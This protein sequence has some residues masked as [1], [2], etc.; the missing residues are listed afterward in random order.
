MQIKVP[1]ISQEHLGAKGY[2]YTGG[3][4]RKLP[5]GNTVLDGAMFTEVYV[6]KEIRHELPM[7]FLHGA[8]Q[9]NTNWLQTPDGRKG[10]ADYFVEQ[11]YV[12]YLTE[13]P[14][15]ARSPYHPELDGP[16][17]QYPVESLIT[18]FTGT[19]G[20]CSPRHT[21]WPGN[22]DD[23]EDPVL[24]QFFAS[25]VE[26]IRDGDLQLR[27]LCEAYKE[28][29]E[30]TGPVILVTHSQA[31]PFGWKIADDN[32]GMVK[33]IV[34]VEPSGMTFQMKKDTPVAVN[35]G[36]CN[37]PL[38][39]V[40]E[41]QSPSELEIRYYQPEDP[42]RRGGYIL[43]DDQKYR[44]PNLMGTPVLIL[45]TEDSYHVDM[46][47]LI[48][49]VLRQYGVENEHVWLPDAGI[50]G[51][52]HMVMLEENNLEVAGLISAWLDRQDLEA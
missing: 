11:G 1:V 19:T 8:G 35:Y 45:T 3:T 47:Y 36:L 42:E 16:N 27:M 21:Q 28:L 17:R 41:V 24:R 14:A 2:F 32:P 23:P 34:A 29:F 30:K 15:R 38:H 51:N 31:G 33:A 9:T 49:M 7:V 12:V 6:P 25:Q 46:D 48:S 22:G 26:C 50:Y 18:S 44:L 5:D 39:I 52:S 10:W 13:Q 20:R 43:A 37:L 4:Y 40:P